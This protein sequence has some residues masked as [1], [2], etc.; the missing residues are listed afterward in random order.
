MGTKKGGYSVRDA[1]MLATAFGL[2]GPLVKNLAWFVLILFLSL[3]DD[4]HDVVIFCLPLCSFLVIVIG[5]LVVLHRRTDASQLRRDDACLLHSSAATLLIFA[6]V[7]ASVWCYQSHIC[8]GGHM[9]HPPYPTWHY[10][11]DGGWSVALVGSV[12]WLA[13]VRSPFSITVACLASFLLS[14][15]FVFGSSGGIYPIPI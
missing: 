4:V 11:C 2:I 14:F 1:I 12:L 3:Y 5:F 7:A 8:C 15:R 6:A 9:A 13:L 10:F